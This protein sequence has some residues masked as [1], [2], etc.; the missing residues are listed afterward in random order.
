M[1]FQQFA[2]YWAVCFIGFKILWGSFWIA[3]A[4][5]DSRIQK[6]RKNARS[7]GSDL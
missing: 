3:L 7:F 6:E 5:L 2:F 4:R 1:G